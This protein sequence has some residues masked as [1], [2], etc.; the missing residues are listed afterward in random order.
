MPGRRFSTRRRR[1]RWPTAPSSTACTRPSCSGYGVS[2]A[3]DADG[4]TR[5][6]AATTDMGAYLAKRA[7]RTIGRAANGDRDPVDL[8]LIT[9]MPAAFTASASGMPAPAVQWQVSTNNGASFANIS[10]AVGNTYAFAATVQDNGKRFRVLF[11]ERERQLDD[12]SGDAGRF[13]SAG[14]RCGSRWVTGAGISRFGAPI[15]GTWFTITSSSG[16]SYNSTMMHQWGVQSAGGRA[17]D[18]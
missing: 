1:R 7:G 4:K 13:P 14:I 12:D 5:P 10:G 6:Q 8:K 9:G 18:G 3:F 17:D 2:I 16:Y 15:S 11:H